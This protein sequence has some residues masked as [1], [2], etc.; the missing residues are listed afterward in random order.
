MYE[1]KNITRQKCMAFSIRIYNLCKYLSEEK[2]EFILSKQILKAGTSIGA[3]LSEAKCAISTN[4]FLAKVYISYKECSET[5]YWL[6]LLNKVNLLT[7]KEFKSINKDA[8]E[9]IKLLSSTIITTKNKQDK[10]K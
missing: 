9:I 6:E 1:D 2:K 4:D 7:E 10:K 5:L 3:N 8:E